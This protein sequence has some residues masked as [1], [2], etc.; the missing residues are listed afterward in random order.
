MESC[1]ISNN[2]RPLDPT[3]PNSDHTPT[4]KRRLHPPPTPSPPSAT[5]RPSYQSETLLRIL[6]P[7]SKIGAFF[8]KS[9]SLLRQFRE[10]TGAQI[11]VEDSGIPSSD[12]RVI[13]IIADNNYTNSANEHKQQKERQGFSDSSNPSMGYCNEGSP[14]QQALVR[15]FERTVRVN[16]DRTDDT[17][18]ESI[19]DS[20]INGDG[21][22][23]KGMVVCR[24]LAQSSQVGSVL[25]RGGKIVE[26]IRQESGAQI[27][28]LPKD[29][30]PAC[31]FP[32]DELIQITGTFSAVKKA[33]FSVS[34]CLQDS[35]T[36]DAGTSGMFKPSGLFHGT[37]MP[38]QVDSFPHRGYASSD[39]A[40]DCYSRGYSS[41]P[42]AE[43]IGAGQQMFVE[44]EVVFK[45]LCQHDKVG[46]LIGKGGSIVRALQIETGASIKVADSAPDSDEHVVVISAQEDAVIRVHCR[47][48]EIGFE[49]GAAIIARLLVH[50]QQIG[51]LL[52]KGGFIISEMRR[53][54][55]ASIRIFPKEQAPKYGSYCEEVVQVIGSFQSVQDAL[56]HI[57]SRLRETIFPMKPLHPNFSVPHLSPFP[58]MPSPFFRTRHHPASPGHYPSQVGHPHGI[59]RSAIHSQLDHQPAVSPG[60]NRGPPNVDR[61]CSYDR[62]ASPR[63]WTPQEV[64]RVIPRGTADSMGLASG[65]MPLASGNPA[66][67][68]T[69]T[70]VEVTIPQ[71]YL[72][73][74]IGENNS[75]LSHIRQISGAKVEVHE[76]KNGATEGLVI[77]SGVPD[78]TH[79]A[80]SLIQAFILCGQT[81]A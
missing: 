38:A 79:A 61:S 35:P 6:C 42:G 34:S 25:G 36:V 52:G 4:N 53:A 7:R 13:L 14:V 3:T 29:Q 80:Q 24:L 10:I 27:R 41:V 23:I 31:A 77:V 43:N 26:K 11:H 78:Q 73:Y 46:S 18:K 28:V 81:A 57:T 60:M 49:P 56:F 19:S 21:I 62:P 37:A 75:N 51:C 44:E 45:L 68:L 66:L 33:L 70:T 5:L 69:R 63:S 8:G 1:F 47:I 58:E 64:G 71:T 12:E 48:A 20:N 72:T 65:N 9:G 17:G 15:V 30:I 39:Y 76:P 32:G 16:E 67:K 50:S 74:I 2:K 54:T 55:G 40:A 22:E 59:D